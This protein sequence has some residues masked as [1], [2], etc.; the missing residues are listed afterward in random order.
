MNIR[1]LVCSECSRQ[2]E[3]AIR[4]GARPALVCSPKCKNDRIN[5]INRGRYRRKSDRRLPG[6]NTVC[7]VAGCEA[8]AKARG[9]CGMHWLRQSTDGSCG[10]AEHLT[11]ICRVQGCGESRKARGYCNLH[12]LRVMKD[13]HPGEP[14]RRK[15]T[16]GTGSIH[17]GY[18]TVYRG[19]ERVLEHRY[20]MEQHLGRPLRRNENVHHINGIRHDNRIEN[21]EL[22]V[23]PQL[24]GQRV[25]DLVDFVVEHYREYVEARLTGRPHL[26]VVSSKEGA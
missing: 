14:D 26:F 5:R 12:Y 18:R 15:F 19:G 17:R 1:N 16:N 3:Q 2:F 9:L 11:K 20:V 7:E 22:W 10:P 6:T 4:Q 25:D 8:K 21:L 24:A 13:G 23:K